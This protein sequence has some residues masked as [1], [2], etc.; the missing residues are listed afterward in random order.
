MMFSC[1]RII[2]RVF[3]RLAVLIPT[4]LL[5]GAVSL[6]AQT[7]TIPPFIPTGLTAAAASCG[8][9]NLSWNASTDNVGGSGMY[10]Y[11]INRYDSAGVNTAMAIGAVRTTYSDTN[12]VKSSSTVTYTVVA[13]DSAGNRSAPS[14][15]ETVTTPACPVALAEQVLDN[16]YMDPLGK[17]TATYGSL[18]ALIY[19]KKNQTT[20]TLDTWLDLHDTSTGQTS[21]FLLHAFPGYWQ[22][23][24]DYVLTSATELWTLSFDSTYGGHVLASQY[25]LNGS[26]ATSATLLSTK[27]LGDGNSYPKSMILLKSGALM[28]AWNEEENG[29]TTPDGSLNTGFAYHS[30]TGNWTVNFPLNVPN[31]YGGNIPRKQMALAQHPTD[32]SIW[33][34]A[35]RDSFCNINALHFTETTSGFVVDW[36]NTSY[37]TV[38]NDGNNGPEGE[39][40]FLAAAAD[41]SRNAILLAYQSHPYQ[42]VFIDPLFQIMNAIFL[43]ESYATVAQISST[44]GKSFI[45]FPA[46]FER[47]VQFGFSVLS[48]GTIWLTYQPI[49]Q[50]AL[51]WNQVYA[52][53]YSN[54][55]WSAPSLVGFKYMTGNAGNPTRDPGFIVSQAGQP[56][57]AFLTPDQKIHTFVVSNSPQISSSDT[58]APTTSITSPA[59]GAT[60][61]GTV[62]IAATASDNVAVLRVDLQVDGAV[63][64][65]QS[66]APYT[67]SWGAG[68]GSHTLQTVAYDAAG[69]KGTSAPVTVTGG[70]TADTGPPVV[71]IASP[72]NGSVAR[73]TVVSITATATD[74]VGVARVQFYVNNTLMATDIGAPYTYSWKVPAKNNASYTIK[75]VAYDA[76]GNSASATSTVTAQ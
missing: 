11:T 6:E 15:S 59:S 39:F 12:W 74:N 60:V 4:V 45:P 3:S 17:T 14:S 29:Y 54:N 49:D 18:T 69:N 58:T 5:L 52:S 30:S 61:S 65:S 35:K 41:P 50:T 20:L 24:T 13:V 72:A 43:K 40:P 57:V 64:G 76:A 26:P 16:A 62:S 2:N 36:I 67:F 33:V 23:E 53:Q 75:A 10:G 31:P 44:G 42:I 7:D 71:A 19:A 27:P 70:S 32:A 37:I 21:T 38:T 22:T 8:Q 9:I 25:R 28:M 47:A 55:V 48:D 51:T 56:R 66:S 63:T 68:A 1:E 73:N 46:P 34:F